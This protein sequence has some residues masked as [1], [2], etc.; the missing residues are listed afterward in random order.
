V[1]SLAHELH[2]EIERAAPDWQVALRLLTLQ[3]LQVLSRDWMPP[4]SVAEG[5]LR[6]RRCLGRLMPSLTLVRER[7]GR[8][9]SLAEA[10]AA[11]GL[12]RSQFSAEFRRTLG[13][14]FG[15][16]RLRA[17]LAVAAHQFLTS[18]QTVQAVAARTG[19]TDASHLSRAF[20]KQYVCT[21]AG[22]R[23]GSAR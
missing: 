21:P 22:Y 16:F 12:G 4:A 14:S 18:D 15:Q 2:E 10:A 7:L 8:E 20:R 19:F 23:D 5:F 17:R 11:C 9:V 1:L 13:V 3:L 6:K